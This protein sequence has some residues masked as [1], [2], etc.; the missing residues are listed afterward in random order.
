MFV[1]VGLSTVIS[2]AASDLAKPRSLLLQQ[3]VKRKYLNQV[4]P[5]EGLAVGLHELCGVEEGVVR[6]GDDGCSRH[7]VKFRLLLF[8]PLPQQLIEGTVLQS[9]ATG[10]TVSLEFFKDVKILQ[11]YLREPKGFNDDGDQMLW[12]WSFEGH[13][14]LYEPQQRIRFKVQDVKFSKAQASVRCIPGV[15][16]I[17]EDIYVPPMVVIGRVDEDGLGMVT[18]WE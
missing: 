8:R 2:L 5:E 15:A 12:W 1:V 11:E 14:L 17:G 4:L 10:L 7:R 6:S 13:E 16:P 9:D 3:A 18:W